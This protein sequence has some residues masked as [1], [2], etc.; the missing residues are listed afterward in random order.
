M[1]IGEIF[2]TT[3]TKPTLQFNNNSLDLTSDNVQMQLGTSLDLNNITTSEKT[4]L[5]LSSDLTLSRSTA[6]TLGSINLQNNALSLGSAESDLTVKGSVTFGT[7][8][9]QINTGGADL[10]L[11]S[12]LSLA[13]GKLSSTAGTLSF[14]QGAALGNNAILDFSGSKIKLLGLLDL[15][16]GNLN[17]KQYFQP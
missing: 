9:S 13:D 12:A 15:S 8:S 5:V 4:A 11:Q 10:S 2:K 7:T 6:F 3:G 1:T 16:G 14:E 17:F